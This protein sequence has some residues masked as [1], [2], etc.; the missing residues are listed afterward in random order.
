MKNWLT[1]QTLGLPHYL[2]AVMV[3]AFIVL[4]WLVGFA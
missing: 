1:T 4:V 3:G 2:W